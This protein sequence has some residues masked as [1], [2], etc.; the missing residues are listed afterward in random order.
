MLRHVAL[1]RWIDGTTGDDVEAIRQALNALPAVIPALRDYRTGQDAG[2][3]GGNWDFAVVA[4][5]DDVA[6]WQAYVDHPAHQKVA[7]ELIRPRIGERAAV[8]YEL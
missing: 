3:A 7:A 1:F 2:L 4:D 5:V 8:Q 6:G